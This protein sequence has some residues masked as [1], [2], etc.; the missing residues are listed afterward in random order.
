[1]GKSGGDFGGIS[2]VK[3]GVITV[4]KLKVL[5]IAQRTEDLFS[6]N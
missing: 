2:H 6:F 3:V 1:M 5:S 4:H